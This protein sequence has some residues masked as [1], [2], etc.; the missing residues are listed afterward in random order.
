MARA[1]RSSLLVSGAAVLVLGTPIGCVPVAGPGEPAASAARAHRPSGTGTLALDWGDLDRTPVEAVARGDYVVV[2]SWEHARLRELHR[3]NPALKVL[4]YK[5]V[6]AVVREPHESGVFSTGVSLAEAERRG[7]LLTDG[8]GRALEWADW[9]GLHPVDVGRRDYQD[10][11][12]A[13]VLAE[14]RQHPWDGV[15]LDDTLTTLSHPTVGGRVS[16]QI[17][18]DEAMYAATSS[19]LARVAP[20]LRRAGHLAVPNVTVAWDTWRSTLQDW[21][22]HVSGWENEYFVKWGL[23]PGPRFGGADWRWKV[24]MAAWC[25]RRRVPLLAVTYGSRHDRAAQVYHRATWLL[26]WNGVTGA[27]IY[28]PQEPAAGH[29]Q[30]RANLP[31]GRPLTDRHVVAGG[32]H[33]RDY[34]RGTVLVNPTARAREVRAGG[35]GVR[36]RPRTALVLRRR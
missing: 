20:R 7:W 35:R 22:R 19:F 6:S 1:V 27:S 15:L 10:A 21:S 28:V 18:T 31:L 11:W 26:T 32:V 29:R 16:T 14:L 25:A 9:R 13:N 12:A 8:R 33:R 3:A 5:D 17:P 36:L 24:R 23:G 2:Q 4:M 34:T 30:P